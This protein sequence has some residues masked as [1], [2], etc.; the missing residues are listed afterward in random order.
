MEGSDLVTALLENPL[1][2]APLLRSRYSHVVNTRNSGPCKGPVPD[3]GKVNGF[4]SHGPESNS[5][6]ASEKYPGNV[7]ALNDVENGK[8]VHRAI[9]IIFLAFDTAGEEKIGRVFN[10]AAAKALFNDSVTS[11]SNLCMAEIELRY[12]A[13]VKKENSKSFGGQTGAFFSP[14]VRDCLQRLF[15]GDSCSSGNRRYIF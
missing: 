6:T 11:S 4:Y 12:W 7:V 2:S 9:G 14:R 5:N 10:S 1:Q 13:N 8:V 3:I 15:S